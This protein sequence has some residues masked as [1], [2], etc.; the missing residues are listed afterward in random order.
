MKHIV[1]DIDE[2]LLS[3]QNLD[4]EVVGDLLT[5]VFEE[6]RIILRP[7]LNEF[8]RYCFNNFKV[9]FS[10]RMT[11]DRCY[12][13]LNKILNKNQKPFIVKTREDCYEFIPSYSSKELRKSA[14][15]GDVVWIDDS[16]QY[17]DIDSNFKQKIIRVSEFD[18]DIVDSYLKDLI[19][20]LKTINNEI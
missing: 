13:I 18:G 19:K 15:E 9:S 4:E 6:E 1:L 5:F 11:K 12:F 8:L 10:T 20:E 3:S 16:P 14:F 17:I 2:C 7:Y